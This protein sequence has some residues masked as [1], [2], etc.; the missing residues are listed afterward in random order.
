MNKLFLLLTFMLS[1]VIASAQEI[2]WMSFNEAIEAQ[3]ENPK[4]IFMDTFTEWCGPCKMLDK[5]TF[6]D[7]KVIDYINKNYY[8]VK[9]NAEGNEIISFHNKKFTNPGYNEN[10]KS[11]NAT[12]DFTMYLRVPG[13]PSMVI[14]DSKGEIVKTIVGYKTP[15][16]LLD[17]I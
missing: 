10:R 5:N 1:T 17:V 8:A 16:Q 4:P 9:F 13:Y 3:K 7:E 6:S 15:E 2:K 11:R 12:H 14:L